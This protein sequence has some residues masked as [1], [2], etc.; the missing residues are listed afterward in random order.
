MEAFQKVQLTVLLDSADFFSRINLLRN[1]YLS[2]SD[3]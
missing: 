1:G 2:D 3:S